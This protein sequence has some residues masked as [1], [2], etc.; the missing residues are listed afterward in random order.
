M[1]EG[2]C[3]KEGEDISRE[4]ERAKEWGEGACME[5]RENKEEERELS[6]REE[7]GSVYGRGRGRVSVMVRRKHT[8]NSHTFAVTVAS[9]STP[10]AL[11]TSK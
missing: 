10:S 5:E 7:G 2:A 4:W 8:Q 3:I 1:G 11:T 9:L 6:G